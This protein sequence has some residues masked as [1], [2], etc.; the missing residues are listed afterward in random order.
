MNGMEKTEEMTELADS[1][2]DYAMEFLDGDVM[3]T[4]LAWADEI[5]SLLDI[6]D[7]QR[8]HVYHEL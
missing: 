7:G 8:R 3:E 6:T 5:Y 1:M 4:V 2:V